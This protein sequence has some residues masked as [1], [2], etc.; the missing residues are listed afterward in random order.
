MNLLALL[1]IAIVGAEW[2]KNHHNGS[3]ANWAFIGKP[4]NQQTAARTVPVATNTPI[5][6]AAL[7]QN[8]SIAYVPA[9]GS[10]EVEL[11]GQEYVI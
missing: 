1:V 9:F 11:N 8:G 6:E 5:T 3:A 4:Q 7:S 10:C 2:L